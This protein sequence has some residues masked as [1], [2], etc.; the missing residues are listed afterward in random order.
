M[1]RVTIGFAAATALMLSACATI[2]DGA[3]EAQAFECPAGTEGCDPIQPVGPGGWIEVDAGNFFFDVTDGVPITGDIEVTVT[4]V[5]EIFHD[6]AALG[7]A[8][9]SEVIEVDGF[10]TDTGVVKLFPGDWTVICTV[11]GHREAGMEFVLTVFADEEEAALA[12]Q[13]GRLPGQYSQRE[14]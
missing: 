8:E 7:A 6:F 14:G 10:E 2:P 13:E 1:R 11:P 12:E 5:S 3:V 4:N 9:G